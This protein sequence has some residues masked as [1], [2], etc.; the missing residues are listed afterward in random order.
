MMNN[1]PFE[2][3]HPS[4]VCKDKESVESTNDCSDCMK[5]EMATRETRYD[6]AIGLTIS[7]IE[8]LI[9]LACTTS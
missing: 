6:L 1:Q 4:E 2:G 8:T 3:N 9:S 7:I 5:M